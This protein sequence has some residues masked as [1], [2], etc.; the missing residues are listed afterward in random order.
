MI[1]AWAL[2][3]HERC[4]ASALSL[5]LVLAAGCTS[6]PRS[7]TLEPLGE[8]ASAASAAPSASPAARRAAAR[9]AGI[10]TAAASTAPEAPTIGTASAEQLLFLDDLPAEAA[11]CRQRGDA[12]R[13]LLELR[14]AGDAP[15][16]KAALAL[17]DQSGSVAGLEV[18]HEMDGGWRGRLQLV[19]ELPV[20]RHRR[21][22]DWIALAAADFD[23]FFAGLAGRASAPLPYRYEPLEL[24]FFRSVGRTTPSAY[25]S[26]W[27]IAYNVSGSLH[28]HAD[29]VRETMFH[30]IF[31]LNDRAHGH[32]SA[33]V[34]TPLYDAIVEGCTKA[35]KLVTGC[36]SPYAPNDTQVRGGTYY[37]F[38]PGN[39]V[40]E[41]AAELA[42]RYY[43]EQRALLAGKAA[44]GKP[45]KCG[46]VPNARA[47]E[48][49]VDEFFGGVDLSPACP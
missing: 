14:Y 13:C 17:Y 48:R 21:H 18:A 42:I 29:A 28:Y 31:H 15:A 7:T 22:L 47:W 40:W 34:L 12:V 33:R 24:K 20:G 36:L 37:A 44:P 6:A 8:T 19:P 26:D 41:Y 4:R 43:R 27:S 46:P 38:Q 11:A 30:E 45:F 3:C 32:W 2:S 16:A 5:A 39:G 35:G 25:A 10:P 49:L 9:D 23:A 1:G